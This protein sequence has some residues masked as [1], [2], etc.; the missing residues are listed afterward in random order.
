[1]IDTFGGQSGSASGACRAGSVMGS[2]FMV[3]A[4]AQTKRSG[5][6]HRCSTTRWPGRT[7][8]SRE[9]LS[10]QAG[11]PRGRQNGAPM[12]MEKWLAWSSRA[13]LSASWSHGLCSWPCRRMSASVKCSWGRPSSPQGAAPHLQATLDPGA[14]RTGRR[15]AHRSTGHDCQPHR[16]SRSVN[17]KR[18]VPC[19]A[20]RSDGAAGRWSAASPAATRLSRAA[21][22]IERGSRGLQN[23]LLMLMRGV[24]RSFGDIAQHVHRLRGG[25]DWAL[26][27][28]GDRTAVRALGPIPSREFARPELLRRL[29]PLQA[30]LGRLLRRGQENPDRKAAALCR[31][32]TKWWAALWTF[33]RVEG[34][35]PNNNAA[36]RALRPR[37]AAAQGQLRVGQRSGQ[38][39]CGAAANDGS[40]LPRSKG[41]NCSIS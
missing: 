31:E 5:S 15:W 3:T 17:S 9:P 11:S 33:A 13:G 10:R 2:A 26:G 21:R 20:G 7:S 29:V 6:P 30:R 39:L 14:R 28:G 25:T 1:M 38:S 18:S 24:E 27:T 41:D 12:G 37:R 19:G 36:E 35:E 22:S 34:V 16:H 32:L 4:A 23:A 40:I 8:G